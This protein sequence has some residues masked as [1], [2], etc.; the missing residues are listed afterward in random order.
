MDLIPCPT[1]FEFQ[2]HNKQKRHKT[3]KF[4]HD[5]S[6]VIFSLPLQS[7]SFSVNKCEHTLTLSLAASR[8]LSGHWIHFR[9]TPFYGPNSIA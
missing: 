6:W 7:E 9:L 3:P 4:I 2:F 1:S 5:L 8:R